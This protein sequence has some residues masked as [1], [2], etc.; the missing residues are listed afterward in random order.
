[1]VNFLSNK[2]SR[3]NPETFN[4]RRYDIDWIR[5]LAFILLIFYHIGQFYVSDW[6]WHVKS[7]YLSDFLKNIMLLV[8]QWRMPLIFL[9]SGVALSLVEA[10]FSTFSLLKLRFTRVFLPLIIGMF[11]IVPP[12]VYY[13][14]VQSEGYAASYIEF[15][16]LYLD[17]N[18]SQFAEHQL[19]T[20][21]TG[22]PL[23][24]ITYNHLWYLLYLFA[25]TLVYMLLKPMLIR[26]QWQK[27][28]NKASLKYILVI[29]F[30]LVL[31]YDF[32]L[33][34]Y[35][36]EDTFVL[37]GDWYNHALYFTMFLLG[38]ILAKSPNLWLTIIK[39]HKIWLALAALSYVL[40]IIRFNRAWGFDID[41][42][43]API[44][45]QLMITALW[46]S[47]KVFWLL[48]VIGCAGAYLNK[49]HP[50]LTYMNDAVLPWYI[51]HQTLIIVFAMWLV[52]LG[53]GPVLEPMLLILL[54]FIGCALG[55]EVIKRFAITRLLFGL[56][57]DT[58]P[59]TSTE[60]TYRS[61]ATPIKW[62]DRQ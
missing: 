53:L 51:L 23:G 1:M 19:L 4:S 14:L 24:L 36:P 10:K 12:Q 58:V 22:L 55:Y 8:N 37:I 31:F 17:T 11:L 30:S 49:N 59:V 28:T 20:S 13:E 16:E 46:S 3:T 33:L 50:A 18:S 41:Y 27:V 48:A 34:D 26:V 62:E 5:T 9:I 44:F 21:R 47:N 7:A 43:N 45:A 2:L 25:Y 32:I 61:Y 42:N 38:Y 6:G 40:V 56:K 60:L 29:P 52:K 15:L 54:T 35:F 39:H 57:L